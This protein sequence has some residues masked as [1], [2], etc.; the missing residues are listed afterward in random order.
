VF[1]NPHTY[2]RQYYGIQQTRLFKLT[3]N[4]AENFKLF[5]EEVMVFFEAT[6]TTSNPEKVQV[7]RLLNLIG[8][9][10]VKIYRTFNIDPKVETVNVIF[11]KL[12]G[13]CTPKRNEI[14]GTLQ[15]FYEKTGFK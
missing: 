1:H 8:S 2:D 4:V 14:I 5:K 10:G 3:G 12:E 9:D 15:I 13:Y 7:A 6:E 11:E